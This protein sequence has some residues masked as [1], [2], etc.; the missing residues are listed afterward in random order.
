MAPCLIVTIKPSHYQLSFPKSPM[1]PSK[2]SFSRCKFLL[3]VLNPRGTRRPE[4]FG[5]TCVAFLCLCV[6]AGRAATNM[7]PVALSGF[8]RDV[9]IENTA[10]GPPYGN[11]ALEFNPGEGTGFY[12]SG[13]PGTSYGLPISGS[14][15]SALGDGTVFQFQ[16]YTNNN[17]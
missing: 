1:P 5:L 11:Y 7:T 12:Q 2:T 17:A 9:V 13:L 6:S 16:P 8:N 4:K 3:R 14:F 15:T 10:S